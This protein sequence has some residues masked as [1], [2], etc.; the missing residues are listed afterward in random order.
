MAYQYFPG[1]TAVGISF[2]NGVLLASERRV[3]F[4]NFVVNKSTKKTFVL[5]ENVGAACAGMVADMN[6]L[7]RQVTALSKIRK[8]EIR[9]D[10]PTNSVAKLMS[11]IMFERRYF[12]LLTQVIVGG[13]DTKPQIYTLDPLGSLLP[14]EYASVGSGAEMA[15]GV[16]DAQYNSKMNEEEAKDLAIKSIRSSI[17]RDSSSGDGIDILIISNRGKNEESIKV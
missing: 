3:S 17:Q 10:L 1:A 6:V 2:N 11:V 12:P 4:G 7:A 5:T 15:L 14:D 13:Y 8:F 9:R 16:L